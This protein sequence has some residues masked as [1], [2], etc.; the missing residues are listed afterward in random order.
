[1]TEAEWLACED[2][3]LLL[4]S[5]SQHRRKLRLFACECVKHALVSQ[6]DEFGVQV[7]VTVAEKMSDGQ[8]TETERLDAMDW[9]ERAAGF[10][11]N[12]WSYLVGAAA[13]TLHPIPVEA[14][15]LAVE[16]LETFHLELFNRTD[17]EVGRKL[18]HDIFGN[19]FRP[20]AFADSWRS[21][22]VTSLASAIY[23]ERAFDRMPIL[24]D[25][26]EEAGCDQPDILAHC[27]GPGTHVRGCWVVD[28]VLGKE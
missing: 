15:G 1:M 17:Q 2:P 25:A 23:A 16:Q 22:T 4:G 7:V 24:A 28:G 9:S 13:A 18:L 12:A 10:A 6:T 21:E 27:R 8:S 19:P 26:L 14:A 3:S 5:V 20:V 11:S